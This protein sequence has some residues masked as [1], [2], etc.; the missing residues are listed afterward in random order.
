MMNVLSQLTA[1]IAPLML[2]LTAAPVLGATAAGADI[3]LNGKYIAG[4]TI[5]LDGESREDLVRQLC[6][7]HLTFE[8]DFEVPV[9]AKDPSSATLTGKIRILSKIRGDREVMA[10]TK[11][12][13]L[14]KREGNWYVEPKSLKRALETDGDAQ[15]E[16]PAEWYAENW[17]SKADSGEFLKLR[18]GT[19]VWRNAK[20]EAVGEIKVRD[21]RPVEGITYIQGASDFRYVTRYEGGQGSLVAS[22]L[23]K[24]GRWGVL[25]DS[26]SPAPESAT[27]P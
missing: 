11:V 3:E 27:S 24:E 7:H 26:E 18:N 5:T 8:R 12:L 2:F 6:R 20:G 4:Y 25:Q 16:R 14:V 23:L 13:K 19:H 21:G 9:E 1:A 22:F 17:P 15:E 10:I